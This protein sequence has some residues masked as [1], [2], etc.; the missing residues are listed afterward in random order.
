[1]KSFFGRVLRNKRGQSLVEYGI[2]VGAISMVGLV[3]AT[4]LGHKV[5]SL[6]GASAALLPAGHDD[7]AAP[8][9]AGKLV[10]TYVGTDGATHVSSVPGTFT[11]NLGITGADALVTD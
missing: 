8:V 2:L 4:M 11:N 10:K 6:L 7:D 3:A 1:M 5:T 9:F